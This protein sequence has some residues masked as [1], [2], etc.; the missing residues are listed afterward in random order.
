VRPSPRSVR[1]FIPIARAVLA[2]PRLWLP[3]IRQS[4]VLAP[5]GWWRR[6][7]FLPVPSTEMLHF[8]SITQYGSPDH[9]PSPDD[10]LDY[11]EWC[12]TMRGLQGGVR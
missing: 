5:G 1:A 6:R 11:L 7:P 12:E 2:R 4:L 8:R 9:P 10:V 3:A